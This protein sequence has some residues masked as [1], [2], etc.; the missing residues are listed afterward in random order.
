MIRADSTFFINSHPVHI[1]DPN[2]FIPIKDDVRKDADV[3]KDGFFVRFSSTIPDNMTTK[4]MS[5]FGTQDVE[6]KYLKQMT[7]KVV[8]MS[9][10]IDVEHV[11]EHFAD[12]TTI[13]MLFNGTPSTSTVKETPSAETSTS[14]VKETPS[15]E[16][17]TTDLV[18]STYD[19]NGY[20]IAHLYRYPHLNTS[21]L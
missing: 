11:K 2:H 1:I 5:L 3:Y 6:H 13:D 21:R 7:M 10:I 9:E 8:P 18:S 14:T 17:S 4:T 16:T 12:Q 20:L 19:D 15:A